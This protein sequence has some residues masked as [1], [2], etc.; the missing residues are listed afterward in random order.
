MTIGQTPSPGDNASSSSAATTA[1]PP[2][3]AQPSITDELR[4]FHTELIDIRTDIATFA[5]L[6]AT[7]AEHLKGNF[8]EFN[9]LL[10]G[11][12]ET[13]APNVTHSLDNQ[14]DIQ[15]PP[16]I[17]IQWPS[18]SLTQN[19]VISLMETFDWASKNIPASEFPTLLPVEVFDELVRCASEILMEEP[20]VIRVDGLDTNSE[21]VVVG[22]I[23]GQLHDLIFLL[24]DAGFLA[25]NKVFV[26][27]GDYVDRGAWGLETFLLLL[28][29]KVSMPKKVYLL[30]GNHES[31]YCT[32]NYGFKNEV[33][34]KYGDK[35]EDVYGKCLNC[36]KCLPLASVIGGHV[37][38]AHGGLFRSIATTRTR[39]KKR[40][41]TSLVLGSLDDLSKAKRELVNP[42]ES[43]NLILGDVLWSDPAMS[44]GLSPNTERGVGLLWGPDCTEEFL[45]KSNLKLIIRSH[46]GPD[47]REKRTGL[48]G[49]DEGYTIDHVVES[50]KLITVFSAPDYPQFQAPAEKRYNNKGAYIVLEPPH[51]DCPVFHSFGAVTPRPEANPYYDYVNVPDSD[52]DLDLTSMVS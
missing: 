40:K 27:N 39:G 14:S 29:W 8:S 22:D 26:F 42:E 34:A 31:K 51:F 33:E 16:Q 15:P 38:T 13:S 37:Y 24:H 47:A 25:D 32:S 41:K 9:S 50:G 52:E 30:R 43:S 45:K 19:W 7:F 12:L 21:V 6:Q 23:H 3:P 1:N 4:S 10:Q 48:E 5:E 18:D 2:P 46:E 49:M 17:P 28:A 44:L 35:G 36:F 20:N 11:M